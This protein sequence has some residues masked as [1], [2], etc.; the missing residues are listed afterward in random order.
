MRSCK[1]P[2][3]IRRKNHADGKRMR[4]RREKGRKTGEK[5][6]EKSREKE[7]TPVFSHGLQS[8]VF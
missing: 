8:E 3:L 6:S 5:N 1:K 2:H 7:I 4:L